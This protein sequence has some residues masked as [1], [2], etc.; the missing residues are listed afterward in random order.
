MQ[1]CC[2]PKKYTLTV[3][4]CDRVVLNDFNDDQANINTKISMEGTDASQH[5]TLIYKQ[6][7]DEINFIS[8]MT[9]LKLYNITTA[10]ITTTTTG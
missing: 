10:T 5:I 8:D 3:G 4:R 1:N 6:N 2:Q 9:R 7:G